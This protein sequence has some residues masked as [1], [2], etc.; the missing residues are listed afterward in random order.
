MWVCTRV[1]KNFTV[2]KSQNLW[3][4]IWRIWEYLSVD[5]KDEIFANAS[6]ILDQMF[7][8]STD[9]ELQK[10]LTELDNLIIN[11]LIS[12]FYLSVDRDAGIAAFLGAGPV[13]LKEPLYLPK[14]PGQNDGSGHYRGTL[15]FRNI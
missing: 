6:A 11:L 14:M 3:E 1:K 13:C 4:T 9:E 15:V 2:D 7:Y 5:A 10:V 12:S 8:A